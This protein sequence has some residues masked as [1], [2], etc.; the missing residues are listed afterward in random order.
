MPKIITRKEARALYMREWRA[1]NPEREREYARKYR[2][3]NQ[4][5][6]RGYHREYMREW[7][8]A[9]PER[10]RE[11]MREYMRARRFMCDILLDMGLIK[12]EDTPAE[13]RGLV[14]AY[15]ELGLLNREEIEAWLNTKTLKKA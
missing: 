12:K 3:A 9:T 11:Y 5:R 8:A 15:V 7:R 4:E 6:M 2:A 1:A 10:E 13:Q 14:T